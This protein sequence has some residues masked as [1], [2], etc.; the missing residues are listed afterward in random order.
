MFAKA[1]ADASVKRTTVWNCNV[2]SVPNCVEGVFGVVHRRFKMLFILCEF[3]TVYKIKLFITS[4][5]I[6]HIMVVEIRQRIHTSDSI[7]GHSTNNESSE[8][9]TDIVFTGSIP[10]F[11]GLVINVSGEIN[12]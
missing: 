3:W 1:L 4:A 5:V 9:L 10:L 2:G 12:M 7:A 11:T 8:T 6:N